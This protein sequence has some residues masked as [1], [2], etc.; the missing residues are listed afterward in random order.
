MLEV[1]HTQQSADSEL[2]DAIARDEFELHYQSVVDVKSRQLCGVETLVR[3]R[4][5]TKGLI[6]PDQFI[7]LAEST[8]LIVPLGE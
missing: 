5:P 6:G 8:G 1:A 7:P 4:H 2:R 3:W